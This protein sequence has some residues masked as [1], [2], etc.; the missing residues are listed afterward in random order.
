MVPGDLQPTDATNRTSSGPKVQSPIVEFNTDTNPLGE[1]TTK[2]RIPKL[3]QHHLARPGLL[4]RLAQWRAYRLTVIT[5]PAGYGK[6]TLALAALAQM[7]SRA[8]ETEASASP[9]RA[10]WLALSE[11]DD[12]PTRFVQALGLALAPLIANPEQTD[13]LLN[14]CQSYPRRAMSLLLYVLE[15]LPCRILVALDDL[16]CLQSPDVQAI[17]ATALKHS[18]DNV[19][20]MMLARQMP[21]ISLGQLRLQD[22]VLEFQEDDLRLTRAEIAEYL[23]L[24]DILISSPTA[25]PTASPTVGADETLALLEQRTQGWWAG[26]Q[27]ALLSLSSTKSLQT[28]LTRLRGD[29][30]VMAEYLTS[31]VLIHLSQP[32]RDFLLRCSILE[33]MNPAL[34]RTVTGV[35]VSAQLLRQA[36]A[37][38]IFLRSLDDEGEWYELHHLFREL[39]LHRLHL[40]QS[41]ATIQSLY[42]RAAEWYLQHE[43]MAAAL[44]ALVAGGVPHLAAEIVQ[45]HSHAA[46][47][48]YRLAELQQWLNLLPPAQIDARPRLL[49]DLAWLGFSN[50]TAFAP[51]LARVQAALATHPSLTKGWQD[52]LTALT[53]CLRLYEGPRQH[54]HQDALAA[55]QGF[56][57]S[58]HLAR[59]WVY[60]I[61][62]LTMSQASGKPLSEYT[63]AASVAFDAAAFINGQIFVLGRQLHEDLLKAQVE[64]AIENSDRALGLMD[65]Y[66]HLPQADRMFLAFQAGE[67][68]YWQNR[69]PEAARYFRRT[70]A[71]AEAYQEPLYYLQSHA[72]LDLCAH[73]SGLTSD[74]PPLDGEAFTRLWRE[75]CEIYPLANQAGVLLWELRRGLVRDTTQIALAAFDPLG[76]CLA[77]LAPDAADM[78]WLTF[79]HVALIRMQSIAELTPGL[80]MMLKRAEDTA[81]PYYAIQVQILRVR[82]LHLLK[83]HDDARTVMRQLLHDVSAT[84]YARMV[85]DQPDLK[86]ILRQASNASARAFLEQMSHAPALKFTP[87]ERTLLALL[88]AEIPVAQIAEHLVLSVTTTRSYLSRLYAKLGVKNHAQAVAWAREHVPPEGDATACRSR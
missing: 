83:Q 46:L 70:L 84:G 76:I 72:A 32:L 73:A 41:E 50:T 77:T 57:P 56:A 54:L 48:D 69:I 5:A 38:Q 80:E 87:R 29:H 26:L 31:E 6:T 61:A 12:E 17:L 68:L 9:E 66:P 88:A 20:W 82:Q 13:K 78:T 25:S 86:P 60:Y 53:L 11:D 19:R 35:E 42:R 4:T 79:L 63:A 55:I 28:L 58:S 51:T 49:L 62:G 16:H 10:V 39:L 7:A 40:E 74:L 18:P 27:L 3:P 33:R 24:N 30:A 65:R 1:P 15:T 59:G 64:S 45:R 44:R 22:Q 52:E 43:N 34:C 75:V 37:Q 85:L 14:L 2:W 81:S 21:P 71:D 8:A 36:V 23:K 47:L 67:A